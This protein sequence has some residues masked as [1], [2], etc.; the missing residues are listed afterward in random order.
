[1][2]NRPVRVLLVEDH[3]A[4]IALTRKAFSRLNTANH[5]DVVL[6]GIEAMKFLRRQGRY[7]KAEVPDLILLDL[8]MPRMGGREVLREI[9]K[10]GLHKHI[11]VVVLTT[12]DSPG[13]VLD[14]YSLCANSY[15]VKPVGF[16]DFMRLV[17]DLERYW[18]NTALIPR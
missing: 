18:F 13:D 15:L 5:L 14:V 7:T 3:P 10:E 16:D 8:N 17:E 11:P 2:S 1:M 6:D 4:D 12:S 9:S